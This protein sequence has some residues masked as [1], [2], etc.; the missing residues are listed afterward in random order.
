MTGGR[1]LSARLLL[2]QLVVLTIGGITLV[3]TVVL[4]APSL[5][6]GHLAELPGSS[7]ELQ[8]HAQ[9]A[10]TNS[11]AVALTAALVAA[12]LAAGLLS[13]FLTR[14]VSRPVEDLAGAAASVAAGRY[15]VTVPHNSFGRELNAL[16]RSFQEM[17]DQLART[18]AARGRLLADLAHEIR[19]P[20]AT[21][22]AH[23]DG[24]ED[25]VVP[26]SPATY[27]VMRGQTAR[28]RRLTDDIR[29]ASEA[30]E[31]ALQLHPTPVPVAQL[32]DTAYR[33]AT[34]RFQHQGVQLR[35]Q[36]DRRSGVVTVDPDRLQQVLTNLLDNALRHT[37]A[38]GTVSLRS[39]PARRSRG[40]II[41][42]ADTGEGLSGH[43]VEA[44][45][46]RFHRVDGSRRHVDDGG[47]GLGL[48]I[49]RAIVTDHG[50]TLTA[51]S[52]GLGQGATFTLT[53]PT[54]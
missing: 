3:A 26:A 11:V 45:F 38:G 33:T 7:P 25:G 8:L 53:L 37:P 10:F 13:W 28:L 41:E 20:L 49:A 29:Q 19:T 15:D 40:A 9:Q 34:P 4:V 23:V 2:A 39:R 30:Q 27:D 17:A 35:R 32:L 36:A 5:F 43:E 22:E 47:S 52:D 16:S 50:G 44:I 54:V 48:T 24:L 31:H 21:L 12:V 6:A 51:H 14:R 18:D 42:V 1:G 46:E